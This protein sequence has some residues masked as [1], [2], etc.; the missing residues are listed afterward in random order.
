M[1]G[2][3][4]FLDGGKESTASADRTE[5]I[6]G[7]SL[8]AGIALP[9]AE[10]RPGGVT[11]PKR[12][13]AVARRGERDSRGGSGGALE[14]AE[15]ANPSPRAGLPLPGMAEVGQRMQQYYPKQFIPRYIPPR[16]LWL[17]GG[18]WAA[19][20]AVLPEAGIFPSMFS[21]MFPRIFPLARCGWSAEV[22]RRMQPY[23]PK[24]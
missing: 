2:V 6:G 18:G 20:A 12:M 23:C 3:G 15:G 5:R 9:D 8:L 22:G 16:S 24:Q 17:V 1:A 21:S 13:M 19:H 7:G 4:G 14:G 11:A 10:E